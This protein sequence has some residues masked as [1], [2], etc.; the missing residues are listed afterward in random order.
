MEEQAQNQGNQRKD[1]KKK[2]EYIRWPVLSWGIHTAYRNSEHFRQTAIDI[3]ESI[4]PSF[5][6]ARHNSVWKECCKTWQRHGRKGLGHPPQGRHLKYLIP[7]LKRLDNGETLQENFIRWHQNACEHPDVPE[8]CFLPS[9][10]MMHRMPVFP[11]GKEPKTQSKLTKYEL[12]RTALDAQV[13]L[14]LTKEQ[15]EEANK[16][17]QVLENQLAHEREHRF[18]LESK[19]KRELNNMKRDKAHA[20]EELYNQLAESK[21]DALNKQQ[22]IDDLRNEAFN[23]TVV[24]DEMA[25]E[26]IPLLVRECARLRQSLHEKDVL[27]GKRDQETDEQYYL[28]EAENVQRKQNLRE[29]E[30][31]LRSLK[32]PKPN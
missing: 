21:Q 28:T 20:E 25:N 24:N 22:M 18:K 15:L 16:K 30:E 17:I 4:V 12:E 8:L 3:Y 2:E 11:R 7:E 29:R 5:L 32:Y 23:L 1:G 14:V 6:K 27:L 10:N 31:L 13:E 9:V 26:T 19:H